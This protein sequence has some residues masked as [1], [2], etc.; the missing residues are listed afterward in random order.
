MSRMSGSISIPQMA[1]AHLRTSLYCSHFFPGHSILDAAKERCN[2][3]PALCTVTGG[4]RCEGSPSWE[5]HQDR[6]VCSGRI[7]EFELR[8]ISHSLP[9]LCVSGLCLQAAVP[10]PQPT[11]NIPTYL[12][13]VVRLG[14]CRWPLDYIR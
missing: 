14:T 6:A 9:A 10:I 5:T 4:D 2:E 1:S 12:R 7:L 11:P 3:V 8:C 13:H